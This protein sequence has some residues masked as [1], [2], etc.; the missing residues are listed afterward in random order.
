MVM[1]LWDENPLK[2]AVPPYV[3]WGLILVNIVVFFV[4]AGAGDEGDRMIVSEFGFTPAAFIHDTMHFGPIATP[5]TLLTY[6]FLHGGILHLFGNMLF[7]W[8][9]GD[10][11]EEALGPL[12]FIVFYLLSGVGSAL[13]Q[14]AIDPTSA[15]PLIG[16]SGAVS[17]CIAA[18]L[19]IHPCKKV[20]VLIIRFL[21]KLDAYWVIGGW[22]LLQVIDLGSRDGVAHWAHL[23]GLAAGAVLLLLLRRPGL[24]L[25]ECI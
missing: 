9:F 19:M 10:D 6:M 23:G 2:R 24:R 18:Y 17:G 21:V 15:V 1:P 12:R 8:V 11:I 5:L 4:Q 16:A 20:T 25:F 13:T 14:F 7:L 3:T 22:V